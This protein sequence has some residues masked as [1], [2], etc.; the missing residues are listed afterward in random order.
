MIPGFEEI[1]KELTL[2]EYEIILPLVAKGLKI[3]VG[4]AKAITNSKM[5]EQLKK[6]C[7]VSIKPP[8]MR[9]IIHVIR[10]MN[11]VSRLV[12]SKKGYYIAETQEELLKYM[13]S[14]QKREA[15]IHQVRVA[16]Q[17]DYTDWTTS[18]LFDDEGT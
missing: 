13:K 6:N 10:A 17:R 16:L 1:T 9:K 3:R 18:I 11:T 5:C 4:K 8:R 7:D 2:E 14:L 12:A 15:A